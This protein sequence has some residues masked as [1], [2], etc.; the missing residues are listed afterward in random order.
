MA[1]WKNAC[2]ILTQGGTHNLFGTV[3]AH[4]AGLIF[5]I[6][7]FSSFWLAAILLILAIFS[8]RGQHLPSAVKSI[9]AASAL[10][11]SSSGILSLLYPGAVAFKGSAMAAGGL[12]GLYLAKASA[13]ILNPFGALILLIAV[14][15]I[16]LMLITHISMGFLFSRAGTWVLVMTRRVNEVIMKKRERKKRAR[17]TIVAR[18][19]PRS[20]PIVTIIK[21]KPEPVKRPEQQQFPFMKDTGEFKLP[22]LDLLQDPPERTSLEI[23]RESLEMNARR[24]EKKLEDFS[25]HGEVKEILPGPVITMYEFKPAPGIKIS[26]VAGLSDDLALTLRAPSIRIVAPI[27]GKAAI[28]IEI[29]NNKREPVFFKGGPV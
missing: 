1:F 4:I 16:S 28:G 3:G 27:P 14:F 23:Q 22:P 29:P 9:T 25:V 24:L 20:K 26:K 13:S 17:K 19:K 11:I 6:L 15:V 21:P 12:I 8:F 7:G 2:D 10:P 5:H 18:E